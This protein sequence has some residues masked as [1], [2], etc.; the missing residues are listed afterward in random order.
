[1]NDAAPDTPKSRS[2]LYLIEAVEAVDD[3]FRPSPSTPLLPPDAARMK[4]R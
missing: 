1:M 4:R 2:A 3:Q